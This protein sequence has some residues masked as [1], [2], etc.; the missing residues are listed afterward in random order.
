MNET[1]KDLLLDV[2]DN[3]RSVDKAIEE[4]NDARVWLDRM[5]ANYIQSVER[6]LREYEKDK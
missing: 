1:I 3:R 6:V 4:F 2:E 5:V